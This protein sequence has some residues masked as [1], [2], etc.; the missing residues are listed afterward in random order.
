MPPL[1]SEDSKDVAVAIFNCL[2]SGLKQEEVT[3]FESN[4]GETRRF[5]LK[6]RL[7]TQEA[8]GKVIR[9]A[10]AA[11]AT[12]RDLQLKEKSGKAFTNTDSLNAYLDAPIFINEAVTRQTRNLLLKVIKMKKDK[13]IHTVWTYQDRVYARKQPKSTPILIDNDKDL[14][15]LQ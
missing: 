13:R 2:E 11:K 9:A 12:L 1:E 5:Y 7:S 15:K 6:V 10:R 4:T 3:R 8:E 14:S